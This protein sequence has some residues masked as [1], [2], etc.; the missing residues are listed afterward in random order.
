MWHAFASVTFQRFF[1]DLADLTCER[2]RLASPAF[3]F[4]CMLLRNDL[5]ETAGLG[6]EV[7]REVVCRQGSRQRN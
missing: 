5:H 2:K 4:L 3:M 6:P 1:A 7:E